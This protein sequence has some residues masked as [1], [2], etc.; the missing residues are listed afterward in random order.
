MT[1]MYRLTV[2][3]GARR[4]TQPELELPSVKQWFGRVHSVLPG[5]AK[6]VI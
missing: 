5:E 6:P 1:I 3:C 2:G 4:L